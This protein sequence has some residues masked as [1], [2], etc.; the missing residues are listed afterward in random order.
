[1]RD[2]VVMSFR[3]ESCEFR[4]RLPRLLGTLPSERA[5]WSL[6]HRSTVHPYWLLLWFWS[7]SPS[8][9]I[10]AL[11]RPRLFMVIDL[12]SCC[13]VNANSL[14]RSQRFGLMLH[15][16]CVCSFTPLLRFS[17]RCSSNSTISCLFLPFLLNALLS[18]IKG[19]VLRYFFHFTVLCQVIPHILEIVVF[20]HQQIW[21]PDHC[22]LPISFFFLVQPLVLCLIINVVKVLNN[23]IQLIVVNAW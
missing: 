8:E 21:D 3:N 18:S 19:C 1:M 11:R 4:I 13:R 17:L 23:R 6:P 15:C 22:V 20:A 14:R 12:R 2:A 5:K 9:S 10:R 7:L 16:H